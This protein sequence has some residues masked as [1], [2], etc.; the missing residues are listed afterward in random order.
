MLHR[1]TSARRALLPRLITAALLAALSLGGGAAASAA[2][3]DATWGVR[4]ADTAEGAGRQNYAYTVDPGATVSD[5]L[6]VTNYSDAPLDLALSSADGFTNESGQLDVLPRATPSTQLGAW[7][8]LA[9]ST[10][11][12]PAGQ[13]VEVPFTLTVPADI[14]PGDYAG[15]VLSSLGSPQ[16]S[17]GISVDRR[18]GIRVHLR[19]TGD[20]APALALEDLQVDY[21]GTVNPFGTG[22]ATVAFT[23]RNTG[24]VRLSADQAVHLAG[25]FGMLGVDASSMDAAP[26]L[27]PGETWRTTVT[28]EG[29]FPAFALWATASL[30]PHAASDLVA[31]GSP[32]DYPVIEG[33]AVTAAVPWALLVV[34]LLVAAAVVGVVLLTRRRRRTTKAREEARIEGAVAAALAARDAPAPE[35]ATSADAAIDP[36]VR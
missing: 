28:V 2:E 19:V 4:T 36:P 21:A 31:A 1:P 22:A 14:T 34:L 11:S 23:V 30:V 3:G 18:L 5:A 20:L 29:V 24:N 8:A 15:A 25:P 33:S 35:P 16:T 32:A 17:Q 27:L 10:V 9:A 26:E 12:V 7:I 6:I 13:A